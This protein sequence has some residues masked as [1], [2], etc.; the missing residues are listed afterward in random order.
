M[1]DRVRKGNGTDAEKA[2]AHNKIV[3]AATIGVRDHLI[4]YDDAF[5]ARFSGTTGGTP[6]AVTNDYGDDYYAVPFN[7][8]R[9]T[10]VVVLIDAADGHFKETS[11]VS[12]SVAYPALS[13]EKARYL[14]NQ[15]AKGLGIDSGAVKTAPADLVRRDA[16]PF[17][18]QWRFSGVG[19][20]ILVSQTGTVT[21]SNLTAVT[22]SP[23]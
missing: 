8:R 23:G 22:N 17:H 7:D 2:E 1:I 9:G 14:A 12:Q 6:M 15:A 20:E 16:V 11:W 3:E 4:P 10:A 18:P 21:G 19:W 5:A 13:E